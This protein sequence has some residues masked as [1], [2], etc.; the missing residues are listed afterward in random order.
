MIGRA[1][2]PACRTETRPRIGAADCTG[3]VCLP[4]CLVQAVRGATAPNP[5][6]LQAVAACALAAAAGLAAA[7]PVEIELNKLEPREGGCQA[8][9]VARNEGPAAHD[10][11]RLDLVI[12]DRDG[13][14]ARR[15]AVEA[16]P[17]AAEKTVVKAF[18]AEGL[19]CETVGSVLLNDVLSCS[20]DGPCLDAVRVSARP[21][22]NFA[23]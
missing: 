19:S 14:I 6:R 22:L 13:V 16:G 23:K 11:L 10:S 21:P 18:V 17:L 2:G 8:W 5:A 4:L 12:F 15:L 7:S 3:S 1:R 20:G 9:L